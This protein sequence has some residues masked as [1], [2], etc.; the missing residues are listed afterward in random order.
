M[1]ITII[2]ALTGI[3]KANGQANDR[4]AGSRHLPARELF[5]HRHGLGL[6]GPPVR[7]QG[8]QQKM[9]TESRESPR[10]QRPAGHYVS[11]GY[12]HRLRFASAGPQVY[13][14]F[15]LRLRHAEGCPL[16][17]HGDGGGGYVHRIDD[18]LKRECPDHKIGPTLGARHRRDLVCP[19]QVI[20]RGLQV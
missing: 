2:I 19:A 10:Q 5:L 20:S 6:P 17:F 4:E 15:L 14:E 12:V 16:V 8:S 7:I 13:L 1:Y 18:H 11:L 9:E 3:Q